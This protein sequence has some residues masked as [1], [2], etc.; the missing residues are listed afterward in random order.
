VGI[1]DWSHYV[2]L[3]QADA[4]PISGALFACHQYRLLPPEERRPCAGWLLDQRRRG[5]P[6]I[7]LRLV[8][9]SNPAACALFNEARDG[10]LALYDSL[11]EMCAANIGELAPEDAERL[12]RPRRGAPRPRR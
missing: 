1:W 5:I 2:Q 4:E 9:V 11:D 7:R 10:G 6:S 12:V 8:L 3:Q